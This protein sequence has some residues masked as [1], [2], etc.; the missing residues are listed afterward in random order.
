M[1]SF[2][3][4]KLGWLI[5]FFFFNWSIVD[6]QCCVNFCCTAKWLSY[7]HICILFLYSF[8]LWFI[9]GWTHFFF[10]FRDFFFLIDPH[11]FSCLRGARHADSLPP[12]AFSSPSLSHNLT[13]L[14]NLTPARLGILLDDSSDSKHKAQ[15]LSYHTSLFVWE[16]VIMFYTSMFEKIQL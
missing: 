2:T 4:P 11:S 3:F 8:P 6:L 15:L 12:A 13:P 1:P 14:S 9:T 5:S 16:Q 10:N 7:T